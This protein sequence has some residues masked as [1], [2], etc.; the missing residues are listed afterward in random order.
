MITRQ[1]AAEGIKR[2]VI[3]SDDPDKYQNVQ[4]LAAGVEVFHRRE[5]D[6]LQKSCARPRAPPS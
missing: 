5:L 2:I 3:T 4:G 1:L 6:R